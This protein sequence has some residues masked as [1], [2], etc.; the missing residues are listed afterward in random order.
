[1][2]NPGDGLPRARLGAREE[3]GAIAIA[4]AA[5]AKAGTMSLDHGILTVK[6]E[7]LAELIQ[8]KLAAAAQ[9]LRGANAAGDVDVGVTVKVHF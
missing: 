6:N 4:P 3:T 8:S 7:H 9:S 2:P 1:M 5:L